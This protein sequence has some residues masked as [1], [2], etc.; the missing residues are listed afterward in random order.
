M[1]TL[2]RTLRKTLRKPESTKS[3]APPENA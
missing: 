3:S 1:E 2:R